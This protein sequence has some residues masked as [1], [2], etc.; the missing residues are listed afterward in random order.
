MS[1]K[2]RLDSFD[3]FTI[4]FI[5]SKVRQLIG[6]A[7]LTEADHDDLL[8]EFVLDLL[9]RRK[10]FD[11]RF[12]TWEAL[13]VVVCENCLATILERRQAEMRSPEREEGS[14][15][16]PI[17]DGEGSLGEMIPDTQRTGHYRSAQET[18]EL[19]QDVKSVLAQLPARL[20]TICER[21]ADGQSKALIARELGMSRAA[22][23]GLL[24]G[25]R[26]RFEQSNLQDYLA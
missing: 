25:I 23:Y 6:R 16:R 17:Q 21:L 19:V 22:L 24:G 11:P 12:G 1:P 18:S 26:G 10:H 5:R 4:R 2:H 14:L 9:E 13:V 7:G 15:D 3:E 8:Q 20:R